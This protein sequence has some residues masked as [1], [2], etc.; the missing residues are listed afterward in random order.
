MATTQIKDGYQGGSDNQLKVNSD[1]SIN[2]TGS[3]GP[4]NVDANI[5]G[6][7][8]FRTSQ[9]TVGTSAVQLAPTALVN[10]SS[11]SVAVIADP[12]AIVYIGNDNTVTTSTGYPL[13]D[14]NSL[15]LDL[16]DS[17]QIWAISDTPNQTVA[18]LEIA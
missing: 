3:S 14:K 5:N 12:T 16:T 11:L 9:Y 18:V 4:S 17:S 8:A 7:D 1:G 13:Y 15:E 2:V 10:R 6:L